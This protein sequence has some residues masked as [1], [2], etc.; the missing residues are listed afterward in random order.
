M[1]FG[2]CVHITSNRMLGIVLD[3]ILPT[4]TNGGINAYLIKTFDGLVLVEPSQV[5]PL[6]FNITDEL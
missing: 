1:K 2:D 3:R 6:G 5:S 4:L